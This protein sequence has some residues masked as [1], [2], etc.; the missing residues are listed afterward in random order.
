M[1]I[2]EKRV[3]AALEKQRKTLRK[4]LKMAKSRS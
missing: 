2:K 4:M 1:M 3:V